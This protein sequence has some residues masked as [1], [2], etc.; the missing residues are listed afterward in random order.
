MA[1]MTSICLKFRTNTPTCVHTHNM[2]F[3]IFLKIQY[4]RYGGHFD[5][6]PKMCDDYSSRTTSG[7]DIRFSPKGS[8]S[9]QKPPVLNYYDFQNGGY[10]VIGKTHFPPKV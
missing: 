2:L 8:V 4:G 5:F 6:I 3:K 9:I 7:R 10:D 1:A